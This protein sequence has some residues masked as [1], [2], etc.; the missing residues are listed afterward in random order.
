MPQWCPIAPDLFPII[1]L[2]QLLV[3]VHRLLTCET[4]VWAELIREL[5]VTNVGACTTVPPD[6][7][8]LRAPLGPVGLLLAGKLSSSR[9]A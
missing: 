5:Q 4:E 6:V 1:M 8:T 2:A 3:L 7:A 9:A